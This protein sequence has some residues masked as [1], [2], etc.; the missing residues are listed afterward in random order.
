MYIDNQL[1][2]VLLNRDTKYVGILESTRVKLSIFF[3]F[4]EN[5]LANA[6]GKWP[7]LFPDELCRAVVKARLLLLPVNA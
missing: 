7:V 1:F 6:V 5:E 3:S 4:R 2:V